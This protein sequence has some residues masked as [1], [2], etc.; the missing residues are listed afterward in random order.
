MRRSKFEKLTISSVVVWSISWNTDL[1]PSFPSKKWILGLR[2][3]LDVRASSSGTS[4][5]A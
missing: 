5:L 2:G 1:I 4:F 3:L